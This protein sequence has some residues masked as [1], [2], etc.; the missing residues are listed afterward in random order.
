MSYKPG[1]HLFTSNVPIAG[2]GQEG[3][4]V[5]KIEIPLADAK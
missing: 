1:K 4:L 3:R 2:P 5:V